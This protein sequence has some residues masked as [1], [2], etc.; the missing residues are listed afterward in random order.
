MIRKGEKS[1]TIDVTFI[2]NDH[3]EY[4][5]HRKLEKTKSSWSIRKIVDGEEIEVVE[6]EKET[7]E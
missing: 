3:E 1:G 4:I 6:K 2:T 7:I 5:A